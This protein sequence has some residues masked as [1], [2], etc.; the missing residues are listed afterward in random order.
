[1]ATRPVVPED[2]DGYPNPQARRPNQ[3]GPPQKFPSLGNKRPALEPFQ[4]NAPK[5]SK[6]TQGVLPTFGKDGV[7][8][9]FVFSCPFFSSYETI[10]IFIELDQ[11]FQD[12][13]Q[14]AFQ[15]SGTNGDT[16]S[17]SW[18]RGGTHRAIRWVTGCCDKTYSRLCPS[19]TASSYAIQLFMIWICQLNSV[20]PFRL[21]LYWTAGDTYGIR[22]LFLK[23]NRGVWP[24]HPIFC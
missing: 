6:T 4:T 11:A 10:W 2:E 21:A 24:V 8:E 17:Y 13:F 7:P 20:Y 5:K 1:M 3:A 18:H 12:A 22:N 16:Y 19:A 15:T 23:Q 14:D 9:L